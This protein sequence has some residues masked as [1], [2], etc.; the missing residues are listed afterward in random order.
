MSVGCDGRRARSA[1]A[2][3]ALLLAACLLSQ[4]RAEPAALASA[5]TVPIPARGTPVGDGA[6]V[7]FMA[8]AHTVVAVAV[9]T[10][11]VRWQRPMGPVSGRAF[12]RRLTLAGD[13]VLVGDDDLVA[14]DRRDGS[15]RWALRPPGGDGVG[16]HLGDVDLDLVFCG[17]ASGR[18]YAV[19]WRTGRMRWSHIVADDGRTTVFSPR[20]H[21]DSVAAGYTR[22]TAPNGGGIVYLDPAT[23][24]RRWRYEFPPVASPVPIG[25]GSAGGPVLSGRRIVAADSS[26]RIT[27]VDRET[28]ERAWELPPLRAS[29]SA[30]AQAS[31]MDYRSLAVVGSTL[32]ASSL[33]GAVVGIGMDTRRERW[34]FWDERLGAAGFAVATGRDGVWIPFMGGVVQL[35]PATGREMQR[36]GDTSRKN[37][38]PPLEIANW[39]YDSAPRGLTAYFL[40]GAQQ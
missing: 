9:D 39:V 10:G 30:W 36:L 31:S 34:R 18:A 25:V 26:G 40:K 1:P 29:G 20:V 15:V 12:G 23:G 24:A 19:D 14:L 4:P 35:D 22:F 33:S 11:V 5:W 13:L 32:V 17:S 37:A 27:A 6:S 28:G 38:W 2:C 21:G 3:V 7:Y 16:L 8:D